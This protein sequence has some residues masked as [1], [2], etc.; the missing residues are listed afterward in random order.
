M[1]SH[2]RYRKDRV[3]LVD[4]DT[5]IK[6]KIFTFVGTSLTLLQPILTVNNRCCSCGRPHKISCLPTVTLTE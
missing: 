5:Q 6:G 1:T 4:Y 3:G 2:V